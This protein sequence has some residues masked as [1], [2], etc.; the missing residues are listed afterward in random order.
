MMM[1]MA[2]GVDDRVPNDDEDADAA[3]ADGDLEITS[4][5]VPPNVCDISYSPRGREP[6]QWYWP[7]ILFPNNPSMS[8]R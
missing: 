2:D 1:A 7:E 4:N 8:H 3:A 5:D 6:C